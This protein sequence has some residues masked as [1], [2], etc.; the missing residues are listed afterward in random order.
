MR[1]YDRMS[2]GDDMAQPTLSERTGPA[3]EP[4]TYDAHLDGLRAL[5]V[6]LVVA[7]HAGLGSFAG[8]FVGVDIFFVLSGF[9]VTRILLRDLTSDGHV[10][11]R[12][13]Y[14]RR[15]R[16]ILPAAI[17][18]LTITAVAYSAV[19][20]PAEML[21][22]LNGFRSAFLY[23]AN[24]NFIAQATD[25][26]AADVNANPVLHFWSLAIEEQFYL[27]WP[28]VLTGMFLATRRLAQTRWWI[29]RSL[30]AGAAVVSAG[31]ALRVG[32]TNITR[33]Y[34]GTDTRSYQLLA[35]ALIALTPQV[36]GLRD[37]FQRLA[38]FLAGTSLV[39][40]LVLG[41]SAIDIGA[42]SR[43]GGVTALT[44]LLIVALGSS[45][46]GWAKLILSSTPLTYLG[47]ISY[48]VYLWHWP[49]IVIAKREWLVSPPV[50]FAIS[51]AFG[52]IFAA[53]SFH[54]IEQ[55][56]RTARRLDKYRRRVIAI[57]F[58]AS[59]LGGIVMVPL[60]LDRPANTLVPASRPG[61]HLQLLDWRVARNDIPDLP[62][63]LGKPVQECTLV[64]GTGHHIL[65]I[66]DSSARMLLPT[67]TQ[68]AT[69][70]SLS[71]SAAVLSACPWQRGL[72]Y[73]VDLGT[74][75]LCHDHQEDWYE[76][77]IPQLQPD[78]II[79]AHQAYDDPA[80]PVAFMTPQGRSVWPSSPDFSRA[81]ADASASSIRAL[82]HAGRS[83]VIIEPIPA[84]P[85]SLDVL[86]CLSVGDSPDNCGYEANSDTTPLETYYR[87][88]AASEHAVESLDIDRLVCP[89]LPTCDPIVRD[90]I[91]ER[92][93]THLTATFA[94]SLA[95]PIDGL[96]DDI[97]VLRGSR[98]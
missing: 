35:G 13:F 55:P 64:S 92:D 37:R 56:I 30:V 63:C 97:G 98:R 18:M 22:S 25:Y 50:L 76:R 31:A 42:I 77:V 16:R 41:T 39:G 66:G 72:E 4:S 12:R 46:A 73:L 59:M 40:L 45:R 78:I 75:G 48:G 19:A 65:L 24:W 90:I 88:V 43:G 85:V 70:R 34:Y 26:F 15:V 36:F 57:G 67:F 32:T 14:S 11:W 94:L 29:L 3:I 89:R 83:I 96:L 95:E 1:R 8:G 79:L 20:T 53:L 52:T 21:N 2:P 7:F 49:V 51:C 62:D 47:R 84:A 58:A 87:E 71:F 54:L 38:R 69:Q 9:L 80:K 82:E 5:A 68:I 44:A 6:Y 23:A 81:L 61:E 86:S 33:S 74:P 60:I 93:V 17:T 28:L 91:N 27:L 10:N